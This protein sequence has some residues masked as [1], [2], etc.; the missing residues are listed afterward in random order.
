MPAAQAA[1]VG[2]HDPSFDILSVVVTSTPVASIV[3]R[4]LSA[5][6]FAS[7]LTGKEAVVHF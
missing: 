2:H 6:E 1:R 5:P 4:S 7:R 3:Y